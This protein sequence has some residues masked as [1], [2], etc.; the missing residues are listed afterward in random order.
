MSSDFFE[1]L[2][3]S[4]TKL[5]CYIKKLLV[6]SWTIFLMTLETKGSKD[7]GL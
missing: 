6:C 7:V 3:D 5:H 1:I 2:I 4:F